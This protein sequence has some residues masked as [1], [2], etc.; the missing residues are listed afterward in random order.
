M[1]STVDPGDPAVRT[2]PVVRRP[3]SVVRRP[4]DGLAHVLAIA[5]RHKV[6]YG[7]LRERIRA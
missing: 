3:S 4:A 7:Q 2:F 1:T 6:T 5:E